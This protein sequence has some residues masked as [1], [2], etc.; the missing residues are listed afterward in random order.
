MLLR[1]VATAPTV[2]VDA[3]NATAPT[4]P[5]PTAAYV[6]VAVAVA[7]VYAVAVGVHNVGAWLIDETLLHTGFHTLLILA[8]I[9]FIQLGGS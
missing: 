6:T 3:T 1:A 5:A 8:T 9:L 4:A 7:A 2:A